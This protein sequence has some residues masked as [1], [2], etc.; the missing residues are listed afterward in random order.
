MYESRGED[1]TLAERVRAVRTR[2]YGECGGPMLADL[3]G[4]PQRLLAR[5]EAGGPIPAEII[6]K[7]IDL[8][9]VSPRWLL[10]G[11][12]E[13]FIAAQPGRLTG[14]DRGARRL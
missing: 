10:C 6:L 5:I 4:I 2:L 14:F 12:G 13:P 1:A 3:L 8:T 7:L 9:G 11:E